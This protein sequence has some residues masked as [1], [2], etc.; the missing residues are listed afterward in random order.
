MAILVVG[1]GNVDRPVRSDI[2]RRKAVIAEAAAWHL[3]RQIMHRRDHRGP[4]E[5]YSA[6]RGLGEHL[7]VRLESID[8]DPALPDDVDVARGIRP[9]GRAL[10]AADAV[11]V[12][13]GAQL[14]CRRPGLPPV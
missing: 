14:L 7:R 11:V 13:A 5:G 2:R 10:P 12:I 4:A 6:V 1:P 9:D 3:A 8:R